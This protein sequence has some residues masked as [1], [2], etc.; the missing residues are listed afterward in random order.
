MERLKNQLNEVTDI[1]ECL[2]GNDCRINKVKASDDNVN[3]VVATKRY[4]SKVF[5]FNIEYHAEDEIV[6]LATQ[7]KKAVPSNKYYL[8]MDALN[9]LSL[10]HIR[11]SFALCPKT[12]RMFCLPNIQREQHHPT[13]QILLT[14]LQKMYWRTPKRFIQLLMTHMLLQI[15]AIVEKRGI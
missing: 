11:V 2:E 6:Y 8:T 1:I 7:C 5:K 9:G 10:T 4:D 3:L 15:L 14:N 12:F 13:Q